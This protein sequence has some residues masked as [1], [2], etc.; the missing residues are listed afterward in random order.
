MEALSHPEPSSS[1]LLFIS[2]KHDD[3]EIA[4]QVARFV[5]RGSRGEIRVYLSSSPEYEGPRHG[6]NLNRELQDALSEASVVLLIYTSQD[7]DWSYC[8]WE[9]GL[10]TDPQEPKTNIVVFQCSPD[11]PAPFDDQLHVQ[12]WDRDSIHTFVQQFFTEPS[13]FPGCGA[14]APGY[15]DNDIKDEAERFWE[16]LQTVIPQNRA[17][18]DW[19]ARPFLQVALSTD[20]VNA[21]EATASIEDATALVQEYGVIERTQSGLAAVFNRME[22]EEGELF[23]TLRNYWTQRYPDHPAT[24]FTALCKQIAVGAKR[25]IQEIEHVRF[26]SISDHTEMIPL[27]SRVWELPVQRKMLFSIYFIAVH[28]AQVVTSRM[29]PTNKMYYKSAE[30]VSTTD[31]QGM[32]EQLEEQRWH[33]FPILDAN[34][35]PKYIVHVSMVDK[36]IRKKAYAGESSEGLTLHDLLQQ[37]DME[38]MFKSTFAVV[39]EQATITEARQALEAIPRCQDIFVTANGT[40]AEPVLGWLTDHDLFD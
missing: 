11:R 33:R 39:S 32:L 3:K 12:A 19:P 13:F 14:I 8:M 21:I 5:R 36:F 10:A 29:V 40:P 2:H 38:E 31:L 34:E 27:L 30:H 25:D 20:V 4:E 24:W 35:H 15:H 16:T 37:A 1:P 26:R 7:K 9:C 6:Q 28:R 17:T 23:S 18:R 22:F